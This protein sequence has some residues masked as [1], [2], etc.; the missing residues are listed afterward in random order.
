MV[1]G[2]TSEV[3]LKRNTLL[4]KKQ[5]GSKKLSYVCDGH[6]ASVGQKALFN[7]HRK[8]NKGEG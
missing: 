3:G 1:L 4:L 2:L 8:K 6:S 7:G 5:A